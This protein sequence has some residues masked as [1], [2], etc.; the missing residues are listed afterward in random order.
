MIPVVVKEAFQHDLD[1]GD[2]RK[3]LRWRSKIGFISWVLICL[4]WRHGLTL[5]VDRSSVSFLQVVSVVD[6]GQAPPI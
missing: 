6:G 5:M 3:V 2:Q 1:S 4:K